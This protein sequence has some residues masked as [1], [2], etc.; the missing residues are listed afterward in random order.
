MSL[1][2]LL[3]PE[4]AFPLIIGVVVLVAIISIVRSLIRRFF[5][6]IFALVF[7]GGGHQVGLFENI[8]QFFR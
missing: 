2:Y 1:D 8:A 6:I 7:F 5:S 3:S 4:V